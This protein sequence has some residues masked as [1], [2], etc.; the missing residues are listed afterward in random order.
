M[1]NHTS[2]INKFYDA[3]EGFKKGNLSKCIYKPYKHYKEKEVVT[4]NEKESLLLFIQKCDLAINDLT[5][6]L[7]LKEYDPEVLKMLNFYKNEFNKAR[8][9][10]LEKYGPVY[11]CQETSTFKWNDDPFPWE[12]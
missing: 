7:D 9:K 10:Y 3:N 6:Y 5:L 8:A 11:S 4:S 12:K 1:N 2:S